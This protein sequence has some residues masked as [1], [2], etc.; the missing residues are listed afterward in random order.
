MSAMSPAPTVTG[1]WLDRRMSPRPFVRHVLAVLGALSLVLAAVS[2]SSA[3]TSEP[4]QPTTTTTTTPPPMAT[5]LIGSPLAPPVPVPASDGRV[6]LAYEL[7]ITNA[8]SGDVTLNSLTARSG[9]RNLLML[10]G[11]N[12][13]YWVRGLGNAGTPTNV[14]P[15]GGTALVW[16][17]IVVDSTEEVPTEITHSVNVSV[18]KPLAG[19]IP[20]RVTQDI[21]RTEVSDHKPVSIAP[22]LDGLNWLDANGCCVMS[23]HR[24]AVSPIDG[25]LW[26]AQRFAIDYMQLTD[27]FRL[28]TGDTSK[29]QSYP[30]YGTPVHAVTD[31]K[32]VSVT[33]NLPDQVPGTS[34][35]GLPLDQY[36]GNYVVQDIGDGNYAFYAH[37]KPGSISVKPG[38]DLTAG[39]S[40]AA[41]GNSGN[42]D[43]P[44][45]HFHVMDGPNPLAANGLP[46]VIT[47]FRLDQRVASGEGIDTL[48]TGQ[49]APL[50]PGF[51]A[52]E[53]TE[54]M[55]LDLDVMAYAVGQ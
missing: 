10:A 17:D 53:L 19:L 33:D 51:A 40:I 24:R 4:E 49:P 25:K 13:K 31:G 46:F 54:V 14:L 8:M 41:L 30:Y 16:L 2:C 48:L 12:L 20:A 43:A 37:L 29:L 35:V 39:Q 21:A 28:F 5:P 23:D 45:L 32:V 11:N 36:G 1:A 34:P 7:V 3:T 9:D 50:Q 42:S 27:D 47:S 38:D 52:R 15:A 55:P 18:A 22:P 6:H 26:S 44:H